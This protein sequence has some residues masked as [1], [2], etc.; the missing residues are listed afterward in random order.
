[1]M[2]RRGFLAA[3]SLA[4]QPA[5]RPNILFV[6]VDEMRFDAMGCAGHAVVKTPTLDRL[7][8]Q[9]AFF[10]NAYTVSPVCCPSRASTFTGRYPHVHGV[11]RN[12]L[13]YN[14]NEIF[15]PSILKHYGYRTAIAGKLH[16]NPK[17]Y[18][19]GFDRFWSYTAEGPEP[20]LGHMAYL[21][22]KHGKN[23]AKW[24]S[25][26]GTCPWPEDELGKDVGEFAYPL[27][28]FETEWITDRSI[29]YLRD[30]ARQK[31][32]FFLFSS[33]LK[34]HSPSV[35][36][37]PY[38]D[39]YDAATIPVVPLP[40]DVKERRAKLKGNSRRKVVDD[41]TMQRRMTALYYGAI[42]HIDTELK[43]LFDE[44]DRL[45]LRRN[46]VVVF[47]SDHGNMLGDRGL[48]FKDFMYEGSAHVPLMMSVP[49]SRARKLDPVIES[50]DL[51]PTLL[52]LAGIPVPAGIQGR[53]FRPMLEK[54]AQPGWKNRCISDLTATMH[55]AGGYKF[56]DNNNGSLELYD[57]KNDPGEKTNLAGDP[58]YRAQLQS[59]QD[60]LA[61]WRTEQ[62]PAVRIPGM[63]TPDYATVD[64]AERAELLRTAPA[65]RLAQ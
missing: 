22:K 33:Y 17:R 52:D 20:E 31:E 18:G 1:M 57:L 34:P 8:S 12:G 26:P 51:M 19:F 60:A 32:P 40:P 24:A 44:L 63:A 58:K 48:W 50:I 59:A 6:M 14:D 7:A 47:T 4:A 42:S 10:R 30:S 25:K 55:L 62:P 5:P 29:A 16:F 27:E 3:A 49:G 41:V 38:F 54:G 56:I 35:E 46:T 65:L 11:R 64:P 9:S 61:K 45:G 53:S 43:R 28:D 36:P 13:A 21:S 2:T 23:A 15:L 39:M 37:K